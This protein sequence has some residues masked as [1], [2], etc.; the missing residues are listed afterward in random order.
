MGKGSQNAIAEYTQHIP[1]TLPEASGS[2]QCE[3]PFKYSSTLRCKKY[4]KLSK[5]TQDRNIAK[6]ARWKNSPPQKKGQEEITSR[7]LLKT[8]ISKGP[9]GGSVG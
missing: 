2:G 7:D 3:T 4:N 5:H 9:R 1:E 6:M 8:D